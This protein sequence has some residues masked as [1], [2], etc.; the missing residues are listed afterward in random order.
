MDVVPA[1]MPQTWGAKNRRHLAAIA[2]SEVARH[3]R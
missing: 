1:A 3:G 2:Y